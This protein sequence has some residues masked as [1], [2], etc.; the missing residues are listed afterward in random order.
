MAIFANQQNNKPVKCKV[1]REFYWKDDDAPAKEKP[2]KVT[3]GAELTMSPIRFRELARVNRVC[4]PEDFAELV[5]KY[6]KPVEGNGKK[7]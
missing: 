5:K 3:V 6:A 2:R 1:L 4:L 7:G